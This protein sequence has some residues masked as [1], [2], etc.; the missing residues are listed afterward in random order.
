MNYN[1]S[2]LKS[3][4]I[5]MHSGWMNRIVIIV[6]ISGGICFAQNM[7]PENK[8][9]CKL[10]LR[11][12]YYIDQNYSYGGDI[13]LNVPI[14]KNFS[15]RPLLGGTF[16]TNKFGNFEVNRFDYG[17]EFSAPKLS[18]IPFG[19][20]VLLTKELLYTQ[21][22]WNPVVINDRRYREIYGHL[23]IEIDKAFQAGRYVR[24]IPGISRWFWFNGSELNSVIGLTISTVY[25]HQ[26]FLSFRYHHIEANSRDD[27]QLSLGASI[28]VMFG[29]EEL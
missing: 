5:D 19:I 18:S 15:I 25:K 21:G 14:G 1:T 12:K 9:M 10:A 27:S 29:K 6:F 22:S 16:F 20:S 24:L 13:Q 23:Q 8:V 26:T 7:Y 28:G 17:L 11:S 2:F 4:K 3:A